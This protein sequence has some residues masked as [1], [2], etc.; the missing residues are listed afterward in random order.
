MEFVH[1][2]PFYKPHGADKGEP[3][4]SRRKTVAWRTTRTR[5]TDPF[6]LMGRQE[7]ATRLE[8]G[9]CVVGFPSGS[10][11]ENPPASTGDTGDVG[12]IPGWG[13]SPGGGNGN[14]L[15]YSCLK[16][17]MH[18]RVWWATVH[19]LQR[20]GHNYA[21]THKY[22]ICLYSPISAPDHWNHTALAA[23]RPV[24]DI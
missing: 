21:H 8:Q 18:R 17:P 2:I 23:T 3:P 19:R 9:P 16:H 14:P 5:L 15:Q 12:S 22:T 4:L 1:S 24:P 13:R 6:T 11:V 10:V 7:M 20:V